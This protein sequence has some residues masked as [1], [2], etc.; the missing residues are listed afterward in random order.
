MACALNHYEKG[1]AQYNQIC[2]EACKQDWMF[3]SPA[4]LK[5]KV[6]QKTQ[7]VLCMHKNEVRPCCVH[8]L[9]NLYG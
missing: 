7:Q 2:T 3:K 9:D 4:S 1:N 6:P 8:D 5:V